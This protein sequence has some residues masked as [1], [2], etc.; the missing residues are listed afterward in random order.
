[1]AVADQLAEDAR[2]ELR[3][4]LALVGMDRLLGDLGLD[5]DARCTLLR[6][7]RD[8]FAKEHRADADLK[9]QLGDK[10]RKDGRA[11]EA[12]L[13]PH[14]CPEEALAPGL[15][16]LRRRS[17]A[18]V[19]IAA[20]LRAAAGRLCHPPE[21]LAASYLH[22]HANRVLRSAQRAQEMVLY[23]FLHRIYESRA[24]RARLRA[25]VAPV[26]VGSL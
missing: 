16:A 12:L 26:A 13:D 15:A 5:L 19:P 10:F 14:G 23:D 1:V 6:R 18:L 2:G 20:A 7:L 3:W 22:M 8:G 24:A 11:L 4:R 9:T 21:R 17:D 25:T